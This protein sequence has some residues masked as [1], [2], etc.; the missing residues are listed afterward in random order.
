MTAYETKTIDEAAAGVEDI[1]FEQRELLYLLSAVITA[2]VLY[3]VTTDELDL[4]RARTACLKA[5]ITHQQIEDY[6]DAQ[7]CPPNEPEEEDE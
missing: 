4:V 7:G 5:G 3:P 2:R 1:T 6:L